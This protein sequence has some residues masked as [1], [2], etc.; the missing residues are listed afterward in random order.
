MKPFEAFYYH[1]LIQQYA[2]VFIATTVGIT[3]F[4]QCP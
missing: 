3:Q 2:N 1:K 4:D